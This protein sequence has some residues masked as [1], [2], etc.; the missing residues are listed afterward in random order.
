MISPKEFVFDKYFRMEHAIHYIP[1]DFFLI[2]KKN[3][4]RITVYYQY[5]E[6]DLFP[7]SK[8]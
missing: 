3:F 4:G 6:M 2:Y 5:N 1:V 8:Q 7:V